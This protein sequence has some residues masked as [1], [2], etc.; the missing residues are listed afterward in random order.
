MNSNQVYFKQAKRSKTV[1]AK[2][3]IKSTKKRSATL[4]ICDLVVILALREKL[5]ID[6][7]NC[8]R[9]RAI[10]FDRKTYY[11]RCMRIWFKLL[12]IQLNQVTT[13]LLILF[14]AKKIIIMM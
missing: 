7:T 13:P 5:T 8:I 10:Y 12:A 3:C 11:I 1:A 14:G 2:R 4:F 9:F 6:K